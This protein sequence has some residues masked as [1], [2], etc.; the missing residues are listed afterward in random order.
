MLQNA[1]PAIV[2][3]AAH[4]DTGLLSFD[5]GALLAISMAMLLGGLFQIISQISRFTLWGIWLLIWWLVIRT[6]SSAD[7]RMLW[8]PAWP[9]LVWFVFYG[10]W[11]AIASPIPVF[12]DVG[13][14]FFRLIT[15]M[16][17]VAVLT[18]DR[19]W[20]RRLASMTSWVLILN[21]LV[22][23]ALREQL[24]LVQVLVQGDFAHAGIQTLIDRYSGLWG[25]A[26]AAGMNTLILLV[27]SAYGRGW[28]IWL[29][30]VA[31]VG[32]IY[33]TASRTSTYVLLLIGL[34][35]LYQT[36]RDN[37]R[38][39]W[40]LTCCAVAVAAVWLSGAVVD[41]SAVVPEKST[42]ARVFDP[43]ETKTA[44][45]GGLTRREVMDQWLATLERGPWHGYGYAAMGGG[46]STAT[47]ERTDIPYMGT[48]NMYIG[49]WIDG[50]FFGGISFLVLLGFG[51]WAALRARLAPRDQNVVL[52]LWLVAIVFS[53]FGHNF[54]ANLDGQALYL[55]CFLLPRS[56]ALTPD[57]TSQD[58]RRQLSCATGSPGPSLVP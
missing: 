15:I 3:S 32:L 55:L 26:N 9:F 17:A 35:F 24:P 21:L 18:S 56:I 4:R 57:F 8:K 14:D 46:G 58:R 42:F 23:I 49:T 36:L 20:L 28:L 48:H 22:S 7:L 44:A 10:L 43:F 1:S 27:L 38:A 34:L 30:R 51:L 50:G 2:Y 5:T 13:R 53:A 16:M 39:R 52:A 11:G 12:A 54:Q 45:G 29:G 25:N 6:Y 33:L 31:G 37:R 40:L 41:F 19:V 47:A